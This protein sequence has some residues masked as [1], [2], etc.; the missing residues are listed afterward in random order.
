MV[1]KFSKTFVF[2]LLTGLLIG[3]SPSDE[4]PGENAAIEEAEAAFVAV[5]RYKA[6]LD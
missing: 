3:C 4:K 5:K 6:T 2:G 1:S